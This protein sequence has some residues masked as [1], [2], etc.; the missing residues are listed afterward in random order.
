MKM[1]VAL[2]LGWMLQAEAPRFLEPELAPCEAPAQAALERAAAYS[3]ECAGRAVL[4]MKDGAVIFERY[5]NGWSAER[6][7]ALASGTKSF[8]GIVAAAAVSDGLVKLDELV[9]DT[10]VEW[11][12]DPRAARMTVRNLLDLSSGLEPESEL[13]GRSGYGVKDLGPLNDIAG[14]LR[15]GAREK[16]PED[17]Y[18]A[19]LGVPISREPGTVF[20]Y[21]PS[22]FYA[23]G[24]LLS[25]KLA[26]SERAEKTYWDYMRA[27]VLL[28]AQV[29]IPKSRFVLDQKGQPNLPGGAHLTARE[30]A[31]FGEFVRQACTVERAGKD[32]ASERVAL[33]DRNVLEL[34]FA[35]SKANAQYGLTWW[36]LNGASGTGAQVAD[37]PLT[38]QAA[39]LDAIRDADG[40]ILPIAMAA[41]AGK[42]RL[43][44]LPKHGLVIVRFAEMSRGGT[45]FDDT[46]FVTT[47]LALDAKKS[48]QPPST[49][50]A[51]SWTTPVARGP[52]IDYRTFE[53]AAAKA[54]VS[55][56][57]YTPPQY[58]TERE[59]RFPTVY[60]L[61]GSGGGGA[62]VSQAARAFGE[63]IA[64]G[65]MPPTIVVFPNGLPEGMWCDSH[66]G[67]TPVETVVVKELLPEVDRVY[68]TIASREGR[69][70]EGFSM[71]GYGAARLGFA[72]PQVFGAISMLAGGPLHPDFEV[73]RASPT[74]RDELLARV[75]G[76]LERYRAASPWRLAE[77]H[78][79]TARSQPLRIVVGERDETFEF[80]RD[81]HERLL[82]LGLPHEYV[83]LP[84]V[85]HDPMALLAAMGDRFW[86]FHQRVFT[87][88]E[89]R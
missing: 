41:G 10:L 44:L 42:Q 58:D 36:L 40:K 60:W 45:D 49:A 79:E 33:V 2:V 89:G 8:A 17:W 15:G 55:Y 71:G 82:A 6:P 43:Y 29:D 57:V 74:S 81:F 67:R 64:A 35:P 14:R 88:P 23:W 19:V 70:V 30:W 54:T 3:E 59:R 9:V 48:A 83:P 12:D 52:R 85:A 51:I 20:R 72:H 22:H 25:R 4:V 11:K 87:P 47:L 75:W 21:G 27:R 62:G 38:R 76:D 73:R 32:G 31:R 24:A 86:T 18:G 28:P 78:L 80:N 16:A 34:C 13:L 68:R 61:H 77:Q 1:M 84:G 69:I 46:R 50:S 26:A 65:R 66:D 56:H 7:H 37:G 39:Q 63:A 53:S 5:A